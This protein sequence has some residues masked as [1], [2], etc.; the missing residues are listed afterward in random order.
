MRMLRDPLHQV[1]AAGEVDHL[2][3]GASTWPS[4]LP[5]AV[6]PPSG[7]NDRPEQSRGLVRHDVMRRQDPHRAIDARTYES[8]RSRP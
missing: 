3:V 4:G 7:R 6:P 2:P 8:R 5:T 1:G